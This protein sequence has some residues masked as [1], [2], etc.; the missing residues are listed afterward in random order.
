MTRTTRTIRLLLPAGPSR[1]VPAL[2]LVAILAAPGRAPAAPPPARGA[3][4]PPGTVGVVEGIPI[5]PEQFDLLAKPYFE[6]VR[7]KVNRALTAEEQKLLNRNVLEELIRERL[8]VAAARRQSMTVRPDS[9]DARMKLLPYFTVDGRVD[10]A[11]FQAFKSSTT[12]NYRQVASELEQGFLLDAYLRWMERRFAPSEAELRDEFRKR[13][14]EAT[15]RLFW[16]L[17]E[18]VSLEPESSA[19]AIRAYYE[20]HP[21]EFTTQEEARLSYVRVVVSAASGAADSTREGSEQRAL[22]VAREL[23]A[24][25]RSGK[26]AAELAKSHGGLNDTGWFKIGDPVRGLGRSDAL[27]EAIRGLKPGQWAAEPLRLG[28]NFVLARLDERREPAARPFREVVGLA[29][30]RADTLLR[31]ARLDSLARI[32]Y[33]RNPDAYRLPRVTA[34]AVA[35]GLLAYDD[36]RPIGDRDIRKALE[37]AR[38]TAG[39]PDT[40]RAWADSVRAALPEQLRAERRREAAL[41][42]MKQAA[43]RLRRGD[44]PE[45][46]AVRVKGDLTRASLY[47]GEPPGQPS[48]IEGSLLDSLYSLPRGAVVGPLVARDSVFVVRIDEA[49]PAYLAP[50]ESVRSRARSEVLLERQREDARQAEAWFMERRDAYRTPERWV[51]D[52][53]FFRRANPESVAVAEDSLRAYWKAHPLEFTVPGQVHA[54]HILAA[55]RG[56]DAVKKE[57]KRSRI[58]GVLERARAGEDFAAL[59]K[60]FSDD[61]GTASQ[62]GDLGWITRADVVPEFGEAALALEAGQVSGLVESQFGYH[63]IRVDEKRPQTLRPFEDCREEIQR[64]LGSERADSLAHREAAAFAEAASAPGADFAALA[65]PLGG[66]IQSPPLAA[67]GELPGVGALES[68]DRS[69]GSLGEGGVMKEP[70]ALQEGYLVARNVRSVPP[71]LAP[72]G[73]VKERVLRDWQLSRRRA[74]ADSLD[75]R[76]RAA[77]RSGADL[78]SLLVPLGG[79]RV[80]KPFAMAGP[81]PDLARDPAAARDSVFL[82]RVFASRPGTTLPPLDASLGTVY[83][84]VDSVVAPPAPEFAS[85]RAS[86]RRELLDQRIAAWTAR[87]RAR[88]KIEILRKD[89]RP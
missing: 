37:R 12:S 27:M 70:L 17:P 4:A 30:R 32:E 88:A 24:S 11:K 41:R 68:V 14:S 57:E 22:E 51:F 42:G 58:A 87:L 84:V 18:A 56:L 55:T 85:A 76:L 82:A 7:A 66:A 47:R 1:I 15:L 80:T 2:C 64:V 63:I 10:E 52:Y 33:E 38:K 31:D 35:R 79:L 86:I 48:L 53:V 34:V 77:L 9:I 72:F 83:A 54:R 73:E 21:E 62:G 26:P 60:E 89:L 67:R 23:L 71:D 25:L 3:I 5:T 59:A 28:P 46:V 81:I 43:D 69:I 74:I 50:F 36:P 61:R 13:T 75:N 19:E 20:A 65:R 29:K 44:R 16:L 39:V 49:D 45:D 78:E 6:E 40:A 8:W